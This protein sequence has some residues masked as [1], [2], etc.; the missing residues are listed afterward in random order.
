M[1]WSI[2]HKVPDSIDHR[3]YST[4]YRAPL[5]VEYRATEYKEC[6]GL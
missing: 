4:E 6:L 1:L 2:G 3:V 5:R